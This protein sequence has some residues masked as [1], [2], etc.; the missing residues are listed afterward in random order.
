MDD[1][2]WKVRYRAAEA[3]GITGSKK[4]VPFL[5]NSLDDPKDH[6]RYMAAK[7]LGTLGSGDAEKALIARLGDENEFVRRSAG[8]GSRKNRWHC[9]EGSVKEIAGP[10]TIGRGPRCYRICA[11]TSRKKGSM[12][13]FI[14]T[15]SI[16]P[17]VTMGLPDFC[18]RLDRSFRF[19]QGCTVPGGK[20]HSPAF[21]SENFCCF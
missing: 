7:A 6:V 14:T 8:N 10:R 11:T 16:G 3:L 9:R 13:F 17:G 19:Q 15:C 18:T 12:R 21:N 2:D 20:D 4:A 1:P 5:I